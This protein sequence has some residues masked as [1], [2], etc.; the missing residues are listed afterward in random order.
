MTDI[1]IAEMLSAIPL[2]DT[3]YF[4]QSFRLAEA[5]HVGR[6]AAARNPRGV[7]SFGA[8]LLLLINKK[9]KDEFSGGQLDN[10][11]QRSFYA[12]TVVFASRASPV[13]QVESMYDTLLAIQQTAPWNEP[14][15]LL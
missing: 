14:R 1:F 7:G 8:Q 3:Y 11:V 4:C 10:F 6:E 13:Q 15:V 2:R 5:L 9:L 12:Q